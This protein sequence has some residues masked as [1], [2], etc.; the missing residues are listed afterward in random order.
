MR[1]DSVGI[2]NFRCLQAV[3]IEF[4]E[5]TTFIGPNGAGKSTVLRALDWFF[6]GGT[7]EEAD[8]YSGATVDRRIRVR[9]TFSDLTATDREELGSTYA[10]ATADTFTAWRT[11]DAGSDKMTGKAMVFPPF[12]EI[13]A[14][15]GAREKGK[16]YAALRDKRPELGLVSWTKAE[17]GE[18][19]MRE[20]ESGHPELLEEAEA[21]GTHLFGFHGQAKLSGLFDFVL[22]TAD[23]RAGEESVDG[24]NTV[25]GRI[26]ER[27]L[28]KDAA[29]A[30]FRDL[31]LEVSARQQSIT[32]AHLAGQL[33]ELADALSVEVGAF[34]SGRRVRLQASVPEIKAQTARV[35]VS[36]ADALVETTVDRQGHGFQRALLI[37]SLKMLAARG[38][39]DGCESVICLAI[40]EPELF[41]HPTQ[42]RAF[43]SV[44][45]RLAQAPD[46]G[47]QVMYA[48]H[49]PYF[50]DPKYFDQIRRVYREMGGAATHPSV[51][52]SHALLEDVVGRLGGYVKAESVK[53]RWDQVCLRDLAES[54]FAE[55][56]LL[57]EGSC[58]GAVLEGLSQK[59]N[60]P[61]LAV[62]GVAVVASGGKDKM[63]LPYAIL[64][65]L[66]IPTFVLFDNDSGYAA[67][68]GSGKDPAEGLANQRAQTRKLL[69]FLGC[70]EE[71]SPVG[72]VTSMIYAYPDTLETVLEG[73]WP[74]WRAAL[75]RVVAD[76]RGI[77]EK[78]AATY[79]LAT[80]ECEAEP[81]EGG[82][83]R[84]VVEAVRRTTRSD[85]RGIS[86]IHSLES[87]D[88]VRTGHVAMSSAEVA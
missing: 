21:G 28:D 80:I 63:F 16:A 11:W 81:V 5:I 36:I 75:D 32:E 38:C 72:A 45:R 61:S 49:S 69:R 39:K 4:D 51:R 47:L 12:E 43:A 79:L 15:S 50:V 83:L 62:D 74:Q 10:P 57:V 54:F 55:S 33:G 73:E 87:A 7:L 88:S 17:Q 31:A 44:L 1:I 30:E 3:E 68:V 34:T 42:A 67:R 65:A 13:R 23:L 9:V 76:G 35:S 18:L 25:I 59:G 86:L 6:N 77:A 26:L 84:G 27:A 78:N 24:R 64:E 37:S 58:D 52:I 2:Q 22:V 71:D 66:E 48:T 70:A 56:V 41:Q 20:W 14:I 82:H 19:A 46:D 40:E 29:N 85:E 60:G 8:V 53:K